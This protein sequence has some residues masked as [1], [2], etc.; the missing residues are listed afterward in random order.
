MYF[1]GGRRRR[2]VLCF[3]WTVVTLLRDS[4]TTRC[5]CCS[6][7]ACVENK[8]EKKQCFTDW[9]FELP[10]SRRLLLLLNLQGGRNKSPTP[11]PTPP[12]PQAH[13]VTANGRQVNH[14]GFMDFFCILVG[15]FCRDF[16]SPAAV[17]YTNKHYIDQRD[18]V[19]SLAFHFFFLRFFSF[20]TSHFN[21][22]SN[23]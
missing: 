3:L 19:L 5:L 13:R 4:V 23:I 7:S 21:S 6:A 10:T 20:F 15:F 12:L 11:H 16:S 22:L 14:S 17:V 1:S 9:R 8:H 18:E 2:N